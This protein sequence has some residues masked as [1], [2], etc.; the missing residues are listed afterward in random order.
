MT[1]RTRF[2]GRTAIV[3]GA[4]S[5]IGRATARRLAADGARVGCLDMADGV[6]E[7]AAL[8]REDGGTAVAARVDV[9]DPESVAAAVADVEAELGP[10]RILANVAGVLRFSHTEGAS[11]D[12]WDL[13]LAVNLKGPFLMARAVIPSMLAHGGG[14][15]V[16]VASSAG[17]FGQAFMAAYCAS[18][19][20]VV[21]LTRSLAWEYL[22][23]DI[24][25]NAIAPG[26]VATPMTGAVAFPEGM[27]FDL[28]A[29]SM[30]V[31]NKML[32]PE[33]PAGLIAFLA[34]DEAAGINGAI[35]PIDH[36]I[37]A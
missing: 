30:A 4:A 8:I 2:D 31:D 24:R 1:D 22:K 32:T 25:V 15:I 11:V 9:A 17:L 14:T 16:N 12:E 3:T 20:G 10:T 5:G 36:A 6:D 27:D 29:K 19:G 37:T 26:G 33:E 21:Q 18:K 23:R 28:I 34:S 35:V 7:T 13:V